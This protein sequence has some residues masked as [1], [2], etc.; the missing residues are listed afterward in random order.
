MLDKQ[1]AQKAQLPGRGNSDPSQSG[2][3]NVSSLYP[4]NGV[5]EQKAI[6]HHNYATFI[7]CKRTR[8]IW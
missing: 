6:R 5:T 8:F 2:T 4:F 3:K 1:S 7:Y